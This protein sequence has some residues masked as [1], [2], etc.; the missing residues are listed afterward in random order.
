MN[1]SAGIGIIGA[2]SPMLQE[3]FGG[4][5][6]GMPELGYL[7][8]KKDGR[9]GRESRRSRRGLRRPDLA[10]Q[11]LRPHRLGVVIRLPR[12]QDHLFRL[13]VLGAALYVLARSRRIGRAWHSSSAASA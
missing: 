2:A 8:I 13:L 7:D 5:L 6:I 10:V 1:V 12:T 3:T 4:Q 11:H 9:A